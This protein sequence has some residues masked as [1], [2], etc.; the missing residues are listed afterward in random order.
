MVELTLEE[1]QTALTEAVSKNPPET[2]A[3]QVILSELMRR[4]PHIV[5]FSTDAGIINRLGQELVG[6][7]ETAVAELIKNSFDADATYVKLTFANTYQAG[8]S[9]EIEDD[10]L[11]MTR[12]QLLDGFMRLSS[13][14]K[15]NNP[16]SSRYKRRRA[17]RKGIGRFAVQRLG[18]ELLLT[19]QTLEADHAL[20]VRIN[21]DEFKAGVDL[22]TIASTVEHVP[23][24]REEG[25]TLLILNLR[26][27]WS[28]AEQNRVYR[29]ASEVLQP[30]PLEKF[31]KK[32][33]KQSEQPAQRLADPGF[34]VTLVAQNGTEETLVADQEKTVFAHALAVIEGYVDDRGEGVWSILSRPLSIKEEVS[35]IGSDREN[36]TP[37]IYLRRVALK[38][39]YFIWPPEGE[40][41]PKLLRNTLAELGRQQG[42]VRVFRNGFRVLPYG[43]RDDDWAGLDASSGV[44]KVLPPHA[45]SN[46]FAFLELDDPESKLFEETASREGLIENAAFRE[47]RDFVYRV[48]TAAV[49]RVA[50]ARGRKQT[51]G[52]K[53]WA[54]REKETPPKTVEEAAED[55]KKALEEAEDTSAGTSDTE[56]PKKDSGAS[57]SALAGIGAAATALINAARTQQQEALQEAGMLRVLASLGLVIGE[58][59]HEIRQALG[60]AQLNANQISEAIGPDTEERTAF[61]HLTANLS[62]IRGY[63]TYFY[64]TVA[65]NANRELTP[66]DLR[67]VGRQFSEAIGPA[68][69]R[70]GFSLTFEP[71]GYE[72]LT[73]PMHSSEI[74]S[75]LFNFYSNSLKAIGRSTKSQKRMLLRVGRQASTVFLEF[76]D[77]GDG[78]PDEIQDR[79]FNAFF[80]TATPASR[81][82]TATDE[83]QG[84][85]LGLKIVADI[86]AVYKGEVSLI[87]PPLGY[88]TCFK[89]T[90]P[91]H[92]PDANSN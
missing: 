69:E 29:Y 68:I 35:P 49:L 73:P 80:T 36:T 78:I 47:L 39:Y 79:I 28:E 1:L 30:F 2:S 66:Q 86:V 38:A 32:T 22:G 52:Q 6:K 46:F 54:K 88:N 70:A 13:A 71:E 82:A 17:G 21:W 8:G 15:V 41:L 75:I 64:Q 81:D 55:L 33:V 18:S 89:V 72:L 85:G 59:T 12:E 5:R 27:S 60:A 45:N 48:L 14:D 25:T 77:D 10:G 40:Y 3:A 87:E 65:D 74:S 61:E 26:E 91:E 4:D 83:A 90:F 58:F 51:R 11:G 23:K 20:Q 31:K 76:A 43:D 24:Q 7:Q 53:G 44:R 34:Q 19:T 84:S 62:R 92:D 56:Q 16:I 63:S 57:T 37:F 67:V 9:L 42:G 50:E